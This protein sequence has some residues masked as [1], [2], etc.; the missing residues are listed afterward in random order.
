MKVE[1]KIDKNLKETKLVVYTNELTNE[2][3]EFINKIQDFN[4]KKIIGSIDDVK[5]ILEKD[6][7]ESFYTE[8]KK[9]YARKDGKKYRVKS[10]MYELEETLEGTDFVRI[11]NSEIANFKKV[12]C[13]ELNALSTICLK[14][15]SGEMTYVSRRYIPKIKKFLNL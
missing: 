15:K 4:S 11:S 13:L 5:F 9:V 1:V 7:I 3:S 14:F 6:E 8:D 10:K 2:L 12:E